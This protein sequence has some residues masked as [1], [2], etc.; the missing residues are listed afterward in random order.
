[1]IGKSIF[2]NRNFTIWNSVPDYVVSSTSTTML[3][4]SLDNFMHARDV[5]STR[6]ADL[7]GTADRE[8]NGDQT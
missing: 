3:K 1:M 7:T 4:N 5:S 8:E 2:A 6:K